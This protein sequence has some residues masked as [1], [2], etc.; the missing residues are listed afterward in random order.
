MLNV[1][2]MRETAMKNL[3]ILEGAFALASV[4]ADTARARVVEIGRA[5]DAALIASNAWEA[6]LA[7]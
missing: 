7:E 5:Y 3:Q 2:E 6:A 4:E 1:N